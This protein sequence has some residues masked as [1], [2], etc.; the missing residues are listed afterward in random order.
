M[1]TSLIYKVQEVE[2]TFA[3]IVSANCITENVNGKGVLQ[4]AESKGDSSGKKKRAEVSVTHLPV[5][6]EVE[7]DLRILEH[8]DSHPSPFTRL[9]H[10]RETIRMRMRLMMRNRSSEWDLLAMQM[11]G[12]NTWQQLS[13][14]S[15]RREED[16]SHIVL[17]HCVQHCFISGPI[18]RI[19]P[20]TKCSP[21]STSS[22]DMRLSPSR[23]SSNKS[24]TRLL[25]CREVTK[26]AEI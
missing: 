4:R 2:K 17:Q 1:F 5:F 18:K 24:T 22:N 19:P 6:Q 11:F 15:S 25:A 12:C 9:L 23:R 26:I 14:V 20:L 3:A 10:H 7:R 16:A 21:E 13:P 8:V